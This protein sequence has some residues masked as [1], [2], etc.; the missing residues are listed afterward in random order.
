M[1]HRLIRWFVILSVFALASY[2]SRSAIRA[3]LFFADTADNMLA[4]Y[5]TEE[6]GTLLHSIAL[7]DRLLPGESIAGIDVRPSTL[8]LYAMGTAG[9]LY[10][11]N[12]VTGQM[13]P[14]DG[15]HLPLDGT[16]FGFVFDPESDLIR[17]AS[18]SG[19][20]L[21][22]DPD[23]NAVVAV[24]SKIA[25]APGDTGFGIS[26]SVAAYAESGTGTTLYVID[27]RRDVLATLNPDTGMLNTVGSL[28]L[29]YDFNEVGGFFISPYT[30]IAYAAL[31]PS[32]LSK[33]F[34]H[35]IDLTTGEASNVREIGGGLTI[36]AI[37][38]PEPAVLTLLA[39]VA[40][41]IAVGVLLRRCIGLKLSHH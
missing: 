5:D 16:N 8:E 24:D 14:F 17:I 19:Q 39:C 6:P 9:R 37:T 18:T 11:V 31:Q 12:T 29:G 27:S 21:R 20:S 30:G 15:P 28:G 33:S 3:E 23:N 36:T 13:T 38:I 22:V 25:Y 40:P 10:R 7:Y 41:V 26:P 4:V 32:H 34:L 2:A 1:T 35:Q